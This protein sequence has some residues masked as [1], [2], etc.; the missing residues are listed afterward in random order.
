MSLLTPQRAFP[1]TQLN[2]LDG[3]LIRGFET[4][5]PKMLDAS[6]QLTQLLS[7]RVE[8]RHISKYDFVEGFQTPSEGML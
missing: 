4:N 2:Y 3:K 6:L 5:H 7:V 1:S 8:M